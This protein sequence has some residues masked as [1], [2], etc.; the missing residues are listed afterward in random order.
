[1]HFF[2][3][4]LLS[5]SSSAAVLVTA[6]VGQVSDYVVTSREVQISAVIESILYPPKVG[7]KAV[8]ELRLGQEAFRGAVTSVLLESV[9]ALEAEN[10]NVATISE[11]NLQAALVRVE[12]AT[13]GKAFW[14]ELDVS[15]AELKKFMVRKLTAKGF[16]K[17]KTNSMASIITDQDAQAYFDKNRVKFGASTFESFRDNIK[18]FLAQQQLEDRL[19]SWFE[20]IKRKYKVRNYISE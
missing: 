13:A 20:V 3:L 5:F 6:T 8:P 10:F 7:S 16:M 18:A 4:L 2:F 11:S 17:F 9:V 19:R 12:K 1:M 15:P 14:T